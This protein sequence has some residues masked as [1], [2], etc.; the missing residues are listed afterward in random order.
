MAVSSAATATAAKR[1][2]RGCLPADTFAAA[3]RLRRCRRSGWS[4]SESALRANDEVA[5]RLKPGIRR[6]L[7]A[8]ANDAADTGRDLIAELRRVGFEHGVDGLDPRFASERRRPSDH[9]VQDRAERKEIRA[10]V[11]RLA[12]QLL[13]APC[14]RACRRR[15]RRRCEWWRSAHRAGSADS[16]RDQLGDAEVQNLDPAVT[17]QEQ[18]LRLEIAMDNAAGVRGCQARR[19]SRPQPRSRGAGQKGHD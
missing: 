8:A 11:R 10:M 3:R 14:S 5:R 6:L 2:A 12:A 13:R 1:E 7:E 17:R 9:L 16:W 19:R 4:L 18:I 15:G